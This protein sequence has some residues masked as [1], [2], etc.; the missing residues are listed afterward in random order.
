MKTRKSIAFIIG[1]MM[2]FAIPTDTRGF[3]LYFLLWL[4]A[5]VCLIAYSGAFKPS[6]PRNHVR[7]H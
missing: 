7:T 3:L 5:A 1:F 6:K 4:P 2:L